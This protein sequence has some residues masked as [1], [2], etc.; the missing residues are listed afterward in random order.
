M[1]AA[2]LLV[3][4][5][6]AASSGAMFKPGE[7]YETLRKPSWT[8]PKWAFPVVWTILYVMIGYAGWLV[9]TNGGWSLPMA[10]WALQMVTNALWSYFFFGIRRMDIALVDVAVLWL[11][12]AL[13]IVTA[14][15]LVPLASLLFVP[16]LA[17]VTAAAALNYSVRRLNPDA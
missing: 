5:L 10:L 3:I 11:S 7:W 16:Y 15:S 17:W 2:V 14:W 1:A 9:W 8:P 12:V 6:A 13:F 4:V